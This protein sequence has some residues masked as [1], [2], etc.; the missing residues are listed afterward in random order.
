M[1]TPDDPGNSATVTEPIRPN[2]LTTRECVDSRR[3]CLKHGLASLAQLA[4]GA[5]RLSARLAPLTLGPLSLG[6]LV[7]GQLAGTEAGAAPSLAGVS[8]A[9]PRPP[10]APARV[11]NVIYLFMAGGPSQLELF[12]DKPALRQYDGQAPPESLIA[13]RR[14]AFL[15]PDAKLLGTRQTFRRAGAC[16]M[17]LSNLL[18]FHQQVADKLCWL[19]G[20]KTDVF[21]HGPAKLFMN[22]GFQSPGRP[23]LGAWVSWGLGNESAELPAFVVLQSGPRGPRAGNTLWSSGFLP[24]SHQ[25]IPLRG[26]GTAILDL[27]N[28]PGIDQAEQA[29]FF[30]TVKALNRR[31]AAAVGDPEILTRIAAYETAF[32]MQSSAPELVQLESETAETLALYGADPGEPSFARNCLLARRLVERGTRFVQLYHT[33]WDHHGGTGADL[34]RSLE[35]VCREVDRASAALVLDLERR[36]LLEETL[37]IWGGE[38]G[39]TPM[40]EQRETLGRDHH[41][42]AFTLWLAGGGTRAGQIHGSTDDL[43]FGAVEGQV[44]VHDLHATILHLLGFDHRRL[45]FRFQGRDYRLTDTHGELVREILA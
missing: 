33:D 32:R 34:N 27:D 15:K 29:D 6:S 7:L 19:R 10:Q 16:G 36:G 25:G 31:R 40:G 43:G 1:L 37:V 22:S 26:T 45:T 23:S 9:E 28:P 18:P 13:G 12:G 41:I 5:S 44:H 39:R 2:S 3:N 17:E 35:Q 24:S 14:F 8:P 4:L 42:D 20:V 11:R 30:E 38:F 21:N